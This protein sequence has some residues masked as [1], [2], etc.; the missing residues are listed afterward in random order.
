[1]IPHER[2]K[3]KTSSFAIRGVDGKGCRDATP[4]T[5]FYYDK[6]CAPHTMSEKPHDTTCVWYF[7]RKLSRRSSGWGTPTCSS[8][9]GEMRSVLTLSN[10][11]E[12]LL[13]RV[14][15]RDAL[16]VLQHGVTS[17]SGTNEH[18]NIVPGRCERQ[19]GCIVQ[20]NVKVT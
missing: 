18:Q 20:T 5:L 17:S 8:K 7:A 19:V 4:A 12:F 16:R 13:S 14:F 2:K 1:M 10:P 3:C 11:R 6:N 15:S 9:N